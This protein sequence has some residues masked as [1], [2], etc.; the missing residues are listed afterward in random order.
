MRLRLIGIVLW[1]IGGNAA[2]LDRIAVTVGKHV[3][4]ESDVLRDLRVA[5]FLDQKPV[6]LGGDEKRKAADRLVD[7][8]LILQEATFSRMPLPTPENSAPLMEQVKSGYAGDEAY[9]AA[10]TRY[11]ITE[12]DVAS[13]LL[14]GARAMRYTDLRFRPEIQ[15]SDEELRDFYDTLAA[16]WRQKDPDKVPSFEASREQVEKLMTD[17]RTAQALD[18]WLGTQR[19]GTQILYREQVFQ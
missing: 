16:E 14:A 10:L 2:I 12:E 19:N 7:Q 5:A 15:L 13:H 6:E 1:T 9:H 4:A 11:Q 3:I 8:F 17:Q 18:R